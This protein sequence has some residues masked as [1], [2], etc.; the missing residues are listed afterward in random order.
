[1]KLEARLATPS[2]PSGMGGVRAGYDKSC[3][4]CMYDNV[5]T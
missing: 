4:I 5:C 2:P 3:H 1:M